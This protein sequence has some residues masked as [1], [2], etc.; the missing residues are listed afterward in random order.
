MCLDAQE[1]MK[2]VQPAGRLSSLMQLLGLSPESK[3]DIAK[4]NL[5]LYYSAV[6]KDSLTM[7]EKMRQ[8]LFHEADAFF[9]PRRLW[10]YGNRSG[11]C[12]VGNYN[13]E[14]AGSCD[15]PLDGEDPE[16]NPGWN[17]ITDHA[18]LQSMTRL[19]RPNEGSLEDV[20][21]AYFEDY[22]S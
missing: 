8:T 20:A 15:G 1:W 22:S 2:P 7:G 18:S 19:L 12:T 5:L 11:A 17:L 14:L 6:G 10:R 3:S 21:A 4:E 13:D 9:C 16:E